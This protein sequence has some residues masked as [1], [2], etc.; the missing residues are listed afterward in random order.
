MKS[1]MYLKLFLPTLHEPSTRKTKSVQA[2]TEHSEIYVIRFLNDMLLNLSSTKEC[3]LTLQKCWLLK[4]FRS[5]EHFILFFPHNW[6]AQKNT[7]FYWHTFSGRF[8][9]GTSGKEPTCQGRRHKRH[10][11]NPW[12]GKIPWRRT[13]QPTSVFLPGLAGYSPLGHRESDMTEAT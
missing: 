13:W 11:F 2:L 5:L 7:K 6:H 12:V 4:S 9:D 1:K 3:K 10:G 8:P